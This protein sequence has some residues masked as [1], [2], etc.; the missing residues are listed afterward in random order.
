MKTL[1]SVC[2]MLL[3]S[4][5]LYAQAYHL[6]TDVF[7]PYLSSSDTLCA[8][9]RFDDCGRLS[10]KFLSTTDAMRIEIIDY[11]PDDDIS[12]WKVMDLCRYRLTSRWYCDTSWHNPLDSAQFSYLLGETVARLRYEHKK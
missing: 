6:E 9:L 2:A 1:I 8:T 4:F 7:D 3:I 10:L 5:G 12:S 11:E